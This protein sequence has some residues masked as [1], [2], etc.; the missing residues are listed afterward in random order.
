LAGVT[1]R[2]QDKSGQTRLFDKTKA[3]QLVAKVTGQT[4]EVLEVKKEA[5]KE[6]P[7]LAYD[8]TELQRDANRNYGFS[9]KTTSSV[10]QQLY[11]NHTSNARCPECH[12]KMEVKGDGENKMFSCVC[13]HREKLSAFTK[14]REAEKGNI[15]KREVSS[16]L[17]NQN[18][19]GSINTALAD[20]LAKFKK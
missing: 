10:M 19:G 9:A 15:N 11:E 13:G 14:R 2:W 8:L 3:D 16:F 4:G 18:E 6:L 20:A 5:K 12:K 1:L 17:Q 7:P